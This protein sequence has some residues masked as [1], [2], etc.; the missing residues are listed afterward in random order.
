MPYKIIPPTKRRRPPPPHQSI[1]NTNERKQVAYV[2]PRCQARVADLPTACNVCSLPLV[3]TAHAMP[4]T[5][6]G[7][8][9]RVY[10]TTPTTLPPSTPIHH[11]PPTRL[12]QVSSS[13]LARSYHHLFPVPPFKEVPAKESV[14]LDACHG[15]Q[16]RFDVASSK[17]RGLRSAACGVMR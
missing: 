13:H 7:P 5:H 11:P 4:C 2:C 14:E 10:H 17:V 3:R 16:R 1:L 12:L 6:T 9:A 8:P 15:C